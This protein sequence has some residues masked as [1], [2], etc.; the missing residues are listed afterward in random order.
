MI[1]INKGLEPRSLT[2]YRESTPNASYDGFHAKED[3]RKSLLNDQ[4][5]ICAYCMSRIELNTTR[6]EHYVPQNPE[7]NSNVDNMLDLKYGNMLGVCPGN[8]GYPYEKQICGAH[9]RNN[10]LT[11]N[12]LNE[13]DVETISYSADGYILSSDAEISHDFNKTLNLNVDYLVRNRKAEL[14]KLRESLR[15][16]KETGSWEKKA[17]KYMR[18]LIDAQIKDVYCG[19]LL[20][21]LRKK[22]IKRNK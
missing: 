2:E 15:K 18:K 8:E 22:A 11:V 1:Y 10:P 12:P 13:T 17:E 16:Q 20:W 4:G 19:I 5:Y 14:D 3:V 6:I 21:Y 9:R 7:S